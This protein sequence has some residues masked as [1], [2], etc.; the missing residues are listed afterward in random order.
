MKTSTMITHAKQHRRSR[1]PVG[2]IASSLLPI[3]AAIALTP[4]ALAQPPETAPAISTD[5]PGQATPPGILTPGSIQLE[6]GVQYTGDREDVVGEPTGPVT[7]SLPGALVRVGVFTNAELRIGLEYRSLTIAAPPAADTTISGAASVSIGTKVGI[8]AE[9]GAV[10]E[11]ALA[12]TLAL[13]VGSDAFRPAAVA[14]SAVLAMRNGLSSTINL[15]TNI[16]GAWDGTRGSGVGLYAA[17]L[18]NSFSESFTGFAEVYGTLATGAAPTHA[19]DAGIAYVVARN[20]Q[21]DLFGGVGITDNAPNSFVNVG[22]SLRLP[23]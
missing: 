3:A 11:M 15:Y 14:P 20:L 4:P 19:V 5:R 1:R 10:P 16:G 17:S 6:A 18:A 7:L 21:L 23:R 13:P 2:T 22:V 9:D 8:T 12:L